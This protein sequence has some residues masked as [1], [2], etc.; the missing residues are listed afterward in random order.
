[1][2]EKIQ[3]GGAKI[4][5]SLIA[6]FLLIGV[7][8]KVLAAAGPPQQTG[9]KGEAAYEV[10]GRSITGASE[11][12]P[13]GGRTESKLELA[14][15]DARLVEVFNWAKRQA[16]A[17]VFDGDPVGSWY[18]ASEPGRE[19]FCMRDT[20]HQAMGAHAL[21]LARYNL[22]MLRRFA[23]NISDSRDWC[24]LWEIDRYARPAPVDY[25]NDAEFWYN[26]PA[27]F[28]VLDCCYRMYLWT[29][30][31]TYVNDPAFLEF[32]ERTTNDF[33]ERWDL[34]LDRVMKRDRILNVRGP[35]DPRKRFQAAR[36]I[37]GYDEGNTEYALGVDLL[38]TQYAAYLAHSHIEEVRGNE[39][40]ARRYLEK[41]VAL[42][43][44]VNNTWWNEE[45]QYFYS[46]L[47]KDH[48]LKG[49]GG[50]DLLFRDIV[51]DGPKLKSALGEGGRYAGAEVLY[52]YGDPDVATA[53]VLDLAR[54]R[55]EYPEVS[56]SRIGAIVNG[57]MGI[58]VEFTSPLLAAVEGWWVETQVKT[59]SGLGTKIAWAELRNLPIRANQV[60]VRHEGQRKTVFTN[61]QGPALIWQATFDGSHD[62]LLVNGKPMEAQTE[63]GFLGRKT[64]WVRVTV[65]PGGAVS[66]EIPNRISR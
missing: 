63:R 25:K 6:A 62:I 21:G 52:R 41:A 13:I 44:F 45:G 31:L 38:A 7:A 16:M 34:S 49:R 47:D 20:A 53:Q 42:K 33:V 61:Q 46:Y 48:N 26:L 66:V 11:A 27:N 24:S 29:G 12:Q 1:M 32:Y 15:S 59:L 54:S 64:S 19:A 8:P 56:Y 39:E 58:N 65:G 50:A 57:T 18:E 10:V 14:S 43:T 36:G 40:P 37:P 55:L 23:E 30:D 9:T 2:R 5:F 51:D 35:L 28:D 3:I 17:F 22:N 4:V 60:T